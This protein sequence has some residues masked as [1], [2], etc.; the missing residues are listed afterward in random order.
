[1]DFP[2]KNGG[3]FHSYV[4]LP[5]GNMIPVDTKKSKYT[6]IYSDNHIF[7]FI[8]TGSIVS[9]ILISTKKMYFYLLI[10]MTIIVVY[11]CKFRAGLVLRQVK[12]SGFLCFYIL[13]VHFEM[14][15]LIFVW[16]SVHLLFFWLV[17]GV[18]VGSSKAILAVRLR[19]SSGI[20]MKKVTFNGLV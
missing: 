1:M 2:I 4:K 15:A 11:H 9:D 7:T 6:H 17:V 3:S 19:L 13:P 5:E 14:C 20:R 8:F 12:A 16:I 10:L 18:C